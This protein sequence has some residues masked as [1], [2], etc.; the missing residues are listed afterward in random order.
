MR[1]DKRAPDRE[2]VPLDGQHPIVVPVVSAAGGVGRSTVAAQLAVAFHQRTTDGNNRAVAVC[3][4]LP[5]CASPWPGWLDHTAEHGTSWLAACTTDQFRREMRRSTSAI[6][7]ADGKP[8]W[9]LTDTGPLVPDFAG[10][11]PGPL[12]WAPVL[13][14][15][16][17]AV[18][19]AD[20]LEGFRL[21]RQQAGGGLSTV[22]AW[23]ALPSVRVAAVWVTDLSPAGLSR[24]LEAITVAEACGLPMRQVV[25]AASDC[26]GHGWL[27][28]SRS[29]RML[30]ADRVGAIVEMGHDTA[31]RRD[32]W[33]CCQPE[34][35][36]RRDVAALTTAVLAAA[37]RPAP[38]PS[39]AKDE[40]RAERNSW[41]VA[42]TARAVPASG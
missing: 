8:L 42:S 4:C 21:T 36:S 35:L 30:L 41:H 29:R 19:D 3:D 24:T 7:M 1:G 26:R 22:A 9:V 11:E 10:A 13:R 18:I 6:D 12:A 16:R 32:D 5:R 28:R 15:L 38:D 23:M 34:Q 25:V 33:P 39:G 17:A 40:A 31:L 20:A 2:S 14:H 37:D 27:P